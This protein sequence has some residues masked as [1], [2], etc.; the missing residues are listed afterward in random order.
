MSSGETEERFHRAMVEIYRTGLAECGYNAR[1]FL[2]M[3]NEGGGVATAKTLLAHSGVQMG[4]TELWACG[5]L[6]LTV[7]AHALKP[8]FSSLFTPDELEE[9]RTRLRAHGLAI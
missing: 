3:V 9:A 4:F 5:R 7:E 6:D 8:E 2:Q 1:R